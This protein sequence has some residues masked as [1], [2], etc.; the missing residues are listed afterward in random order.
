M[1]TQDVDLLLIVSGPSL[2]DVITA[3]RIRDL[4]GELNLRVK[5]S[6]LLLNRVQHG[7][8]GS[9]LEEAERHALSIAGIIPDDPVLSKYDLEGRPTFT[10]PKDSQ[11][12]QSSWKIF[13]NLV[14]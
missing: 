8:Q 3:A 5:E 10:L 12:L 14:H 2:R 13:G 1:T 4:V 6:R 11:A 7:V 9:I